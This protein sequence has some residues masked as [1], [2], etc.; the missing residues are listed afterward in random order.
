M[1]EDER[2]IYNIRRKRQ[3]A[4]EK[5][6][7]LY[8]PYVGTIIYN[9]IGAA[10]TK[11]DMEEV[12]SDTFVALWRNADKFDNSKG[13]LRAYLG[14]MA[15]NLAKNKLASRRVNDEFTEMTGTVQEEPYNKI[16]QAEERKT[17][18]HAIN[19]LG[20]PD[21]EIFMRYYYYDEKISDIS[22]IVGLPCN[23]VK[24]K[25]ARGRNKLKII[26]QRGENN[27][28]AIK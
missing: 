17:M 21:S 3:G 12:I 23:T 24:T 10:M 28:Q 19:E 6:I 11:E 22:K 5:V 20:E 7:D 8:T 26:L 4:L 15:R 18:I 2:L 27:E 16:E 9:V 14:T 1:T 25:L 13:S